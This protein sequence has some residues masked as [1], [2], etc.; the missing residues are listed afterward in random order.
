MA[1]WSHRLGEGITADTRL[2]PHEK[3][4]KMPRADVVLVQARLRYSFLLPSFVD[5]IG[6]ELPLA[7]RRSTVVTCAEV[8]P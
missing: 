7:T 4:I 3:R 5:I 1:S 2:K 6:N 8:R